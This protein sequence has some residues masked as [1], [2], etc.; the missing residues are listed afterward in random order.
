M[1]ASRRKRSWRAA[2]LCQKVV[3]VPPMRPQNIHPRPWQCITKFNKIP[4]RTK[5]SRT[6]S[7]TQQSAIAT[8][9]AEI[10]QKSRKLSILTRVTQHQKHITSKTWNHAFKRHSF[11]AL[12]LSPR[13][14][15][16]L[17]IG[18]R[19]IDTDSGGSG[20]NEF[21]PWWSHVPWE[22]STD[23]KVNWCQLMSYVH[24][25]IWTGKTKKSPQF[26]TS[27]K[28]WCG[29]RNSPQKRITEQHNVF[30]FESKNVWNV[31]LD[32][33]ACTGLGQY[34]NTTEGMNDCISPCST[35]FLDL[36][37]AWWHRR[38]MG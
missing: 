38:H 14:H 5:V 26:G 7:E 19:P 32:L 2:G 27:E 13:L 6:K 36:S 22:R 11:A 31:V 9:L 30:F 28:T 1:L 4:G 17:R 24:K 8:E 34:R 25:S 3:F 33:F 15:K 21:R 20:G 29:L 23:V 10:M 12:P 18:C 37:T 35:V 16:D